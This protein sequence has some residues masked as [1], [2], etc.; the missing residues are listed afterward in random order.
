MKKLMVM[1]LTVTLLLTGIG[2]TASAAA[3]CT[4]ENGEHLYDTLLPSGHGYTHPYSI[5]GGTA[6]CSVTIMN[7]YKVYKCKYCDTLLYKPTG[8]T[9][10]SHE[11]TS[12]NGPKP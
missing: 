12:H 9:W 5:T 4:H 7:K 3:S 6:G 11:V 8:D 2:T 10:D 1:A